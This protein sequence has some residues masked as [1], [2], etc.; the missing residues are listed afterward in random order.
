MKKLIL[1][2]LLVFFLLLGAAESRAAFTMEDEMKLGRES[3]EKIKGRGLLIEDGEINEYLRRI[4][5]LI[6]E[7]GQET[8]FRFTYSVI[9]SR[10]INAFATPGGYVYLY[11]GL[12]ELTENESQL[13]G[14][15]AHEIAHVRARH[16]AQAIEKSQKISL[17]TLA[18]IVAGAVLGGGGEATA[19]IT[20]FSM[21]TATSLNLKYSR[22]HEEEADRLGMAYLTGAGYDGRA[23]PDF[24]RI[25]RRY[26]YYS[27]S[28]PS[29]FLTH[30]GTDDRI[31]YLDTLLATS[32][33]SSRNVREAG[34]L[35]RIKT[36]LVLRDGDLN[37]E[38]DYFE[39][40]INQNPDDPYARYGLAAVE[41]KMGKTDDSLR[42]FN[43]ALRMKPGDPDML[44]DLGVTYFSAGRFQEAIDPLRKAHEADPGDL[45]TILYLGR[46]WQGL[47]RYRDALDMYLRYHEKYPENEEV[48]YSIAMAWGKLDDMGNAHY[49]FGK[50]FKSKGKQD[51]ANFHFQKALAFYA[52]DPE[53]TAEIEKEMKAAAPAAAPSPTP[54]KG[55][56]SRG[57]QKS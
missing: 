56:P 14:V 47:E 4:G 7:Q 38:L 16:I 20:S 13:A 26:E 44:R 12:I 22:Q 3:Y 24:L 32:R 50:Y 31:R 18:A 35:N 57:A 48:L 19:A 29:Y 21:A 34:N 55:N 8:P 2:L 33:G 45:E 42:H 9:D 15:M 40:A 23:M 54:G 49:Y 6:T 1:P 39:D 27:S 52:G 28:I 37:Y 25:M 11:R 17:A 51:S 46:A 41:G 36:L 10:G 5:D 43:E 53:R 30:P